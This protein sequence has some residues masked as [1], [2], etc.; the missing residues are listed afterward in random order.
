MDIHKIVIEKKKFAK[1]LVTLANFLIDSPEAHEI[2]NFL[3]TA[4]NIPLELWAEKTDRLREICKVTREKT[5]ENQIHLAGRSVF[6]QRLGNDTTYTG[7]INYGMV[8]T[9]SAAIDDTDTQ[10][11]AEVKRKV[12]AVYSVTADSTNLRFYFSKSD[13]SGTYQEFGTVIDGTSS[14]NTGQMFNRVLTG[15]WTKSSSESLIVT[16]QF[17]LNAA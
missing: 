4:D 8:G 7:I 15:G 10:L 13:T 17:D 2:D 11:T 1:G 12:V 5:L 6:A 9:S 16:V 14:A 3:K